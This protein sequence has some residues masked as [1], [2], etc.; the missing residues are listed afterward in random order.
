MSLRKFLFGSPLGF[1]IDLTALRLTGAA[2]TTAGEGGLDDD[3]TVVAT[4]G[5]DG[6]DTGSG[7]AGPASSAALPLCG[8][9][10][11]SVTE[12]TTADSSRSCSRWNKRTVSQRTTNW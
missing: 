9:T 3:T 4:T 12:L 6:A 7:V 1:R 8:T 10:A 11:A 2:G 5:V